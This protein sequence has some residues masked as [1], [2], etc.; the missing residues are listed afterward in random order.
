MASNAKKNKAKNSYMLNG[1]DK[2][3]LKLKRLMYFTKRKRNQ[4][5]EEVRK[6]GN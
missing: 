2:S 6:Y 3:D 1:G 5:K 4:L